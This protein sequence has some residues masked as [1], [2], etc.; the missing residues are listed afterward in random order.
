M[1]N[2]EL[3]YD[4]NSIPELTIDRVKLLW[5]IDYYDG[6]LSGICSIDERYH[7]FLMVTEM[8]NQGRKYLIFELTADKIKSEQDRHDFFNS[9][10]QS[11]SNQHKSGDYSIKSIRQQ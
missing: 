10:I 6:I 3:N 2:L 1:F 11:R 5:Y 4:I 8:P 7:Y 9:Q